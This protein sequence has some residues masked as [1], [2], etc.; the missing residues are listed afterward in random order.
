MDEKSSALDFSRKK[1]VVTVHHP[2]SILDTT[3]KSIFLHK[4]FG[5]KSLDNILE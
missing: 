3:L 1:V 2:E 5:P 4:S